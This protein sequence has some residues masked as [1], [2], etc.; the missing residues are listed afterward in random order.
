[1]TW[2]GGTY[3]RDGELISIQGRCLTAP[4]RLRNI[5]SRLDVCLT[6]CRS[7]RWHPSR[8][9]RRQWPPHGGG[10]L[11]G[12]SPEDGSLEGDGLARG[13]YLVTSSIPELT[14]NL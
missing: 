14:N 2:P 13:H 1:M 11:E 3:A 8:M 4:P 7:R 12:G 9:P 6:R 10:N 5:L